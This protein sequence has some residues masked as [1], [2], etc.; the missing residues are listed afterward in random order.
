[1]IALGK[2]SRQS[3]RA[4][5]SFLPLSGAIVLAS[6]LSPGLLARRGPATCLLLGI[7]VLLLGSAWMAVASSASSYLVGLLGPLVLLGVGAGLAFPSISAIACWPTR[8]P[9]RP[10]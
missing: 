5:L 8:H 7:A 1:M 6:R 9:A 2:Q 4:G 10:V 3:L